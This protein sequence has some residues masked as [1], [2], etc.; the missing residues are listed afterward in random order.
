M[1]AAS[2]NEGS[3]V[4]PFL[5]E[6]TK[7]IVRHSGDDLNALQDQQVISQLRAKAVRFTIPAVIIFR[8]LQGHDRRQLSG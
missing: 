2:R 7:E 4:Q 6:V 8:V 1:R 3:G 5:W